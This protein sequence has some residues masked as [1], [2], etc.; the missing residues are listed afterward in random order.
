MVWGH[1]IHWLDDAQKLFECSARVHPTVW[2]GVP[3]IWEKAKAHI[4]A[5]LA[6]LPD[7]AR[8]RSQ[9]A[10]AVGR[11][12]VA[13][14]RGGEAIPAELRA[15]WDAADAEV[16]APLRAMLGLD[17]AEVFGTG[18]APASSHVVEFFEALGIEIADMWG[19]SEACGNVAVTPPGARRPGTVGRPLPGVEAELAADGEILLRGPMV[20]RGYRGDPAATAEAIGPDGW[21]RTGDLATI[22][23][24]GYITIVGRKKELIINAAGKNM[25]PHNIEAAIKAELP[26]IE[27]AVAIGDR[28][29]YNVAL[30]VLEPG[31]A[32][33]GARER[34]AEAVAR[35]NARLS[36]VEQIKRFRILDE[37]W[38]PGGPTLTNTS[39]LR[40][41]EIAERYAPQIDELYA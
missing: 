2:G 11:E 7:P 9:A 28:R 16:F 30:I 3:R 38:E 19:L 12:L 1:T 37:V 40:R 29:P 34:V 6:A 8:E 23:D 21:L 33:D 4:E 22:D 10:M 36:R 5:A 18:A 15:R 13:A 17:Q 26:A 24:D 20:M 35:A 27:H 32:G 14:R 25:S 39:K 31:A 41:G